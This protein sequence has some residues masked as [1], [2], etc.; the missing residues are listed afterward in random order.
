M[1]VK[2]KVLNIKTPKNKKDEQMPVLLVKN[3]LLYL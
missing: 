2:V 1:F 3:I